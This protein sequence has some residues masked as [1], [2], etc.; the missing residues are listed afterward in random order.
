MKLKLILP[1]VAVFAALSFAGCKDGHDHDHEHGDGHEHGEHGEKSESH[2]DGDGDKGA[3]HKDGDGDKGA[4]H[5][6]GDGDMKPVAAIESAV[7]GVKAAAAKPYALE[8]CIVGGAKLG[9]MGD[10][11]VLVHNGQ[12]VKFCCES[13]QPKFEADPAKYLAKLTE[14]KK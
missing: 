3:E 1:A 10:P 11:V 14:E 4:E 7:A 6:D 13:C 5:K 12:E 9:S 2:Q 8:T